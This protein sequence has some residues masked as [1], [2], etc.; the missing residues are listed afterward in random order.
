[1]SIKALDFAMVLI[2]VQVS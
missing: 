2:N 1:M